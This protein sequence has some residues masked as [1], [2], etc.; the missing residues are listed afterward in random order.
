[1][2]ILKEDTV[3]KR[4]M[5][6]GSPMPRCEPTLNKFSKAPYHKAAIRYAK[7]KA[8][9]RQADDVAGGFMTHR[10]GGLMRAALRLILMLFTWCGMLNAGIGQ[11]APAEQ[12]PAGSPVPSGLIAGL[13]GQA[14]VVSPAGIS[15]SLR[16]GDRVAV[17]E[18]VRVAPGGMVEMLWERRALF[19]LNETSHVSVQESRNGSVILN[20]HQGT[21]RLAYSYNQGRPSDT[22]TVHTPGTRGVLRGGIVEIDAG[23]PATGAPQRVSA[24]VRTHES[25]R[26]MEGQIQ[27]EST[28]FGAKS[29]TIKAGYEFQTTGDA[30]ESVR[31]FS[32]AGISKPW[33][34]QD[35][36]VPLNLPRL[37]QVHVDHALE[38]ERALRQSTREQGDNDQV[39]E[40][41]K[42]AIVATSLGIPLTTIANTTAV[43]ASGNAFSTFSPAPTVSPGG[44]GAG[45]VAGGGT[46]AGSSAQA[47][48]AATVTPTQSGGI[49]SASL[50][51][52]VLKD[53]GGGNNGRGKGRGKD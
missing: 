28:V 29:S 48:S 51:R 6:P 23:H 21:V 39:T 16:L 50:L 43:T 4:D 18:V 19:S 25:I 47:V 24:A 9:F 44:Q 26:V 22:L 3:R 37:V 5:F 32:V 20:V 13:D 45:A 41:A 36:S 52:D 12:T 34:M 35:R 14:V 7:L 11:A 42:G 30:G 17:G 38:V 1:M 31:S 10:I 2:Q 15:R 27:V 49:N 33:M 53:N 8:D 40:Q 46:P